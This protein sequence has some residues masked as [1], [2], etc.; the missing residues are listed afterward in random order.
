MI[1]VGEILT[2]D[3]AEAMRAIMV[4]GGRV[5]RRRTNGWYDTYRDP[6]DYEGW[7]KEIE[8]A[9]AELAFAKAA[10][11]YWHPTMGGDDGTDVAGCQVRWTRHHNG[12]LLV[13]VG[14]DDEVPCVLVTGSMPNY[15]LRGWIMPMDARRDEFFRDSSWWV[16]ISA[17]NP[18]MKELL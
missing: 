17:L 6:N 9:A 5:L 7:S 4:G 18:N 16:P 1:D 11:H 8:G 15:A 14:D 12:H 3:S 10:D 2:L 13:Y